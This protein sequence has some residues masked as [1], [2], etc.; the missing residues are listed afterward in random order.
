MVRRD[1][2]RKHAAAII[3]VGIRSFALIPLPLRHAMTHQRPNKVA[4]GIAWYRSGQWD[5]LKA[6]CEDRE[7]MEGSYDEWKRG[8]TKALQ[9]LRGK[10]EHVESVDFDLTDFQKWCTA[11]KKRPNASSRS[12][13][14]VFRLRELHQSNSNLSS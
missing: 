13:F 1:V 5:E 7:T 9:D 11:R 2:K 6:F 4:V 3:P 10:G 12:E 8:A 14:T